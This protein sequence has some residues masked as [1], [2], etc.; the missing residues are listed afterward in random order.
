MDWADD[1][2]AIVQMSYLGQE[3]EP[4]RRRLFGDAG[5]RS[6]DDHLSGAAEDAP[7]HALPGHDGTSTTPRASLVGTGTTTPTAW[8]A[9]VLRAR[10]LARPSPTRSLWSSPATGGGDGEGEVAVSVDVSNTSSLIR[11]RGRPGVRPPVDLRVCG[12]IG[13]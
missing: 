13:S 12:P 6:A 4:L 2:A 7:A 8:T 10:P 5:A 9:L 1:V 3:A 11:P